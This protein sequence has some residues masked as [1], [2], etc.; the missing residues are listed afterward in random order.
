[1][2]AEPAKADVD[3]RHGF[4]RARC[5]SCNKPDVWLTCNTCKKSDRFVVEPT[6]IVCHCGAAY[7]FATCTCGANV[8]RGRL[9]WVPFE[10]GPLSLADWELDKR[11]LAMLGVG[12]VAL[13]GIVAY[14]I[15]TF[16]G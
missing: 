4:V 8:P 7:A 16:I 12:S 5:E 14:A 1:M 11:R 3:E 9:E 6:G 2:G 10:K 13:M 15:W